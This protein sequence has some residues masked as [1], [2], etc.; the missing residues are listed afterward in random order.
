VYTYLD[1]GDLS[2]YITAFSQRVSA[3]SKT[4]LGLNQVNHDL[5]KVQKELRDQIKDRER[6]MEK[7]QKETNE[8]LDKLEK[9][10]TQ[11]AETRGQ[12]ESLKKVFDGSQKVVDLLSQKMKEF[13]TLEGKMTAS[14]VELKALLTHV[15]GVRKEVSKNLHE[16]GKDK[17]VANQRKQARKAADE[18]FTQFE[19]MVKKFTEVQ[20]QNEIG[21]KQIENLKNVDS[22]LSH[23]TQT[24]GGKV[25]ALETQLDRASAVLA[26]FKSASG[27]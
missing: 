14:S 6:G 13:F 4:A 7:S 27:T 18:I 24:L 11:L 17:S 20:I 25:D 23:S 2:E 26:Q 22:S 12:L 8:A 21:K 16:L 15:Q 5:D 10:T 19:L 3:L 1:F 9:V